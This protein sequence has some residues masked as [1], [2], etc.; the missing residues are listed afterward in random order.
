M[1]DNFYDLL[2][3]DKKASKADIKKAFRAQAKKHHPDKGGD[4]EQ[5]KKINQAYETL[6]DDNKRANYDR[7]GS[8]GAQ[9]FGGSGG[10]GGFDASQ[11][12]AQ[13]FQGFEDIF[14]S[15]FGGGAGFGGQTQAKS[16]QQKGS[17]L[18]VE[19][20][21]E[22][23]E[24]IK[25]ISKSF[26]ARRFEKCTKCDAK[27]GDGEADCTTCDGR[28]NISQQFQTPFGTVSQQRA[29]G[30]CHGTG[31]SFKNLCSKCHG[32]G[33]VEA[34]TKI[35]INIP[36]GIDHGTT[37]RFRGKGDAG[38]NGGPTGDL[39]VHVRV[40][41]SEQF[42]RRGFDLVSELPISIFEGIAGGTFA[43]ETF[44]GKVDLEVPEKTPDGQ[45]LRIKGK[46]IQRD[47]QAGDHLV[48]VKHVMP[49]K[50]TKDMKTVFEKFKG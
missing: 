34:K 36:A 47:G 31:K 40:K 21:L 9:G 50:V 5:F 13:N 1:A 2:G 11:F 7:F 6:S 12:N 41:P 4:A 32:E 8:A 23:A 44:W 18:E 19:V 15:F 20:T 37:L 25:G 49:K 42:E 43:V 10:F 30:T 3:V 14:S 17:D 35:E 27:G 28:G 16:R 24:S 39:Y 46:G 48:R 29:C 38:K 45:L 33:R 22:F 26:P